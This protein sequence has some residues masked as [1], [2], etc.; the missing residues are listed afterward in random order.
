[1]NTDLAISYFENPARIGE[2]VPQLEERLALDA[3][4]KVQAGDEPPGWT[5]RMTGWEDPDPSPIALR[6]RITPMPLPWFDRPECHT[7]SPENLEDFD[8]AWI[9]RKHL[10]GDVG[11]PTTR[12]ISIALRTPAPD[13]TQIGRLRTI[14][15]GCPRRLL[16][17]LM[18]NAGATVYEIAR[19]MHLCEAKQ[20]RAVDWMNQWAAPP[21]HST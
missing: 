10:A 9:A 11:Q 20:A 19:A 6:G 5:Q 7:R 14:F 8:F 3:L 2:R 12:D 15:E 1:M 13:A 4:E 17:A 16:G 18:E 21:G